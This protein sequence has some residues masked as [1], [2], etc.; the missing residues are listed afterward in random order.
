[1]Q[2]PTQPGYYAL[3]QETNRVVAGSFQTYEQ[4]DQAIQQMSAPRPGHACRLS[5]GT[6][7]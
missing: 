5:P 2:N 1:M 4:A 6:S 7:R 3:N